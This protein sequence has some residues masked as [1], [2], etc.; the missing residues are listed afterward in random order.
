MSV[1]VMAD[2][3]RYGHTDAE[4]RPYHKPEPSERPAPWW[5]CALCGCPWGW[6]ASPRTGAW[7]DSFR[8]H[9]P[10]TFWEQD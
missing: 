10:G 9:Y 2:G 5:K 4:I 8:R 3:K 6:V 7:K 1:R